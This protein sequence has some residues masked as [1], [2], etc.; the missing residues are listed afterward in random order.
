MQDY[1]PPDLRPWNTEEI[2]RFLLNI[3]G[4]LLAVSD[5]LIPGPLCTLALSTMLMAAHL[6]KDLP[7]A[8]S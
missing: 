5:I 4:V 6:N 3:Q 8:M 1:N 2:D 7:L